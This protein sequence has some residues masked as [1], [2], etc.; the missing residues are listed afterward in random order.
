MASGAPVP[1]R[2]PIG[3]ECASGV[4]VFRVWAP[5]HQ[6]VALVLPGEPETVLGREEG[7]YFSCAVGVGAGARYGFRLDEGEKVYPDPASRFQ[8]EGPHGLSEVVDPAAYV[9]GDSAWK[10]ITPAG[11]V[12]YELHIGTF[13]REGNWRGAIAELPRLAELGVTCLE[14]MP[15]A[16][17]GGRF[18]WGYDGVDLFA[19]SH[20]YGRPD[21]FRTFVDTAHRL[22]LGVILDVV[23]NHFG[24]AGNY[25]TAFSKRYLTAKHRNDWGDGINFD[26]E[27]SQAVREFCIASAAHWISEYHL[28]GFRFD[29]TQC[30]VDTSLTHILAELSQAARLAAGSRQIMLVAENEPQHVRVVRPPSLGGYGFDALWNDDWHH[31]ALVAL[32]GNTEAYY[33]DYRGRPQEFISAAK[34]GYLY[35]GQHYRWQHQRRG[36]VTRGA[37]T[38]SNMVH[39]L[40]NH[41]QIANSGRGLRLQRLTS[42]GELRAMT[43]LLLLG[44]QT[45]MLFQGQEFAASTPFH[46]FAD[47]DA[48]LNEA[49]RKGRKRE[50][51]Q[52]PSV[53]TEEMQSVL[54]DPC[55]AA[56]MELCRLDSSERERPVHRDYYQL[57]RDLL[58]LRREDRILSQERRRDDVDGAVLGERAFLLRFFGENGE[59]RLLVVNLGQALSMEVQPEP[60]LAPPAQQRWSILWSSEWPVY[61]GNGTPPLE[62]EEEG[63]LIP[64]R[65]AVLLRPA[66]LAAEVR[67]RVHAHSTS[68]ARNKRKE[69]RE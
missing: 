45:P 16:E 55:E 59:D 24:P 41:D 33:T 51:S 63:W 34:Y 47:H 52:F 66:P 15:V 68:D 44:P 25:L 31:A 14:V 35:Q 13:S 22:G 26:D 36:T 37:V 56:T 12:L 60:L 11:Q 32:T 6:K 23:Y 65:C 17:F 27:G 10:G 2:F 40:Q 3:A 9:W 48:A 50:L 38:L 42:P 7:G 57:H 28:D 61:G 62:T 29:A 39:F 49:I 67:T 64:P 8:P 69:K 5:D 21:E 58:K 4:A 20:L 19:P 46:Y 18:G 53:A 1:R 43:A 54:P 30:I